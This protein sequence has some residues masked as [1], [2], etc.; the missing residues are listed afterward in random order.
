M[1]TL[2]LDLEGTL[3][4]ALEDCNLSTLDPGPVNARP[5][6]MDFLTWAQARYKIVIFTGAPPEMAAK[7][8]RRAVL[9]GAAPAS[10][11]EVPI[12][13]AA[14]GGEDDAP[15]A[16]DLARIGPLGTVLAVDDNPGCHQVPG[17]EEFWI[18]IPSFKASATDTELTAI[19]PQ[20]EALAARLAEKE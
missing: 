20:I 9:A 13:H 3:I 19:R 11:G 14:H 1:F 12:L 5:G 10:L 15:G 16:K 4:A 8:V 17:Q 6:L 18:E 2:A 7:A